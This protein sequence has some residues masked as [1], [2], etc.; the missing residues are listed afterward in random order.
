MLSTPTTNTDTKLG[1]PYNETYT[2]IVDVDDPNNTDTNNNKV[3]IKTFAGQTSP[4]VIVTATLD[5][6]EPFPTN[7][8]YNYTSSNGDSTFDEI[9]L[10]TA[11]NTRLSPFQPFQLKRVL[12]ENPMIYTLRISQGVKNGL[13]S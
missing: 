9:A 10:Q 6:S 1:D 8:G 7:T 2:K 4:D 13:Y 3:E 12:I 11:A 5:Y